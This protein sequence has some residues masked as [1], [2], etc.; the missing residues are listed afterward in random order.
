MHH[1]VGD[2]GVQCRLCEHLAQPPSGCGPL[3][4]ARERRVGE[5]GGSP[6]PRGASM[7]S[8]PAGGPAHVRGG[9]TPGWLQ[10]SLQGP[11]PAPDVNSP[12]WWRRRVSNPNG[13]QIGVCQGRSGGVFEFDGRVPGGHPGSGGRCGL[14]SELASGAPGR[15]GG[16]ASLHYT[17]GC[18]VAHD[19]LPGCRLRR[20]GSG[21]ALIPLGPQ[22]DRPARGLD[23]EGAVDLLPGRRDPVLRPL[24]NE[25]DGS[26][27][28]EG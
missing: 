18:S 11:P 5:Q 23:D 8:P 19:Y 26:G 27:R 9:R 6:R 28:R 12:R 20:S 13:P 15:P 25:D 1:R 17:R 7:T 16:G 22:L 21:L 2:I 24:A 10:N 3:S 14:A 4:E